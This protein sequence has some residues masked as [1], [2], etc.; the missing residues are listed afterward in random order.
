MHNLAYQGLFAPRHFAELGLPAA[1]FGIDGLE[2][3]GQLSFM[4]GGLCFADR[5]TTVSPTYAREIQTPEQGCGLDGLLRS[6]AG[7]LTGILNARRRPG[8][9]S[10]HR[11]A[12]RRTAT[13]LRGWR[14]K[15]RCKAA[16]QDELGLARAGRCAAVRAS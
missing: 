6:R 13:T 15:A 11:R 5:I 14:G 10:G 9:E 3:H 1:A 4:K 12:D 16:L 8:L 7:V 2:Y